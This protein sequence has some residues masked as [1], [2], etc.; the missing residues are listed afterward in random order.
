[1]KSKT[2]ARYSDRL[3]RALVES[4]KEGER[5]QR[6]EKLLHNYMYFMFPIIKTKLNVLQNTK[7]HFYGNLLMNNLQPHPTE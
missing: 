1:M 4:V 2:L 3:L 5:K 7:M 6:V